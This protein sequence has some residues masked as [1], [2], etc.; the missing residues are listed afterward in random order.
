MIGLMILLVAGI[1]LAAWVAIVIFSYN[2]TLK[3]TQS[4]KQAFAV[5]AF[6]FLVMYLIPF[7][8][9]IPTLIAHK[10]YCNTQAGF[11]IY[12]RPEELIKENFDLNSDFFEGGFS[13]LYKDEIISSIDKNSY[14]LRDGS[15]IKE[16]YSSNGNLRRIY[17]KKSSGE[18]GYFINR[19]LLVINSSKWI[20]NDSILHRE[21][22]VENFSTRETI[23]HAS[24]FWRGK[25]NSIFG[26][27]AS[28]NDIRKLFVLSW[29]NRQC[30][31]DEEF[32]SYEA[33]F[34]NFLEKY[35]H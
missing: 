14:K 1:Y 32:A 25:G 3:A 31:V 10:N 13:S 27:G 4:K 15:V 29:G 24:N 12:R 9:V 8:D 23:A 35:D 19:N 17:I 20:F 11:W 33:K 28:L 2:K 26:V 18:S 5:S 22:R 6:F 16:S 34:N 30:L 21:I 7:W